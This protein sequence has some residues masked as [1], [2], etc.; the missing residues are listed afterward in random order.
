MSDYSIGIDLGTT[1]CALAYVRASG[2]PSEVLPI[3]Q[4]AGPERRLERTTLPSFLYRP[5]VSERGAYGND[6]SDWVVGLAAREQTRRTPGRVAHSAK[7]WLANHRSDLSAALLPWQSEVLPAE[8]RISPLDA[9]AVLLAHLREAWE[10]AF[11]DAPLAAQTVTLTVPASFDAAAQGATLEAAERAGFPAAV[12]LLEEPQAAFYRWLE[13]AGEPSASL[14]AGE[15]VLVVDVGGGTSDFSLFRVTEMGQGRGAT[16]IE[17]LAV[18][19]HI[20]LGGDNIDLALAHFLEAQLVSGEGQIEGESWNHLVARARD[21]KERALA[22]ENEVTLRL[23][24]PGQGSGLLAGTLSAEVSAAELREIVLEGFFPFC[25]RQ[26]RP[27]EARSAL[28]EWGLPYAADFAV[29]RYLADFLREH[30]PVDAVLFN[31]GSLASA[32]LRERLVEQ[33]ARWQQGH[34]PRVLANPEPDLAVARG[35]AAYGALGEAS[36]RPIEA[37]AARA[38]F[39]EVATAGPG[40]PR[41]LLCVLPRGAP[42][43]ERCRAALEGLQVRVNQP[44]AFA[45]FQGAHRRADQAGALIEW[46]EDD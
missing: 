22:S 32:R 9:S 35:A 43:E 24:V 25:G 42:P 8:E 20:L 5:V 7:S 45:A 6:E 29:T 10:A 34:A 4:W 31:G 28:Q 33:L 40:E 17:R 27:S 26:E 3:P 2:T 39:L 44:V 19:E 38:V 30:P 16:S 13:A 1:N 15:Q 37:G 12:R 11:P 23:A 46:N 41:R 36:A 18:S 14:R 21:L